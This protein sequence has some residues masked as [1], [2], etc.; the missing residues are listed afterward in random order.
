MGTTMSPGFDVRDFELGT[1]DRADCA[2]PTARTRLPGDPS[3]AALWR[4]ALRGP[5][6]D[7]VESNRYTSGIC[8]G[9]SAACLFPEVQ[10]CPPLVLFVRCPFPFIDCRL[11]RRQAHAQA[12][13]PCISPQKE[14]MK[15][16]AWMDGYGAAPHRTLSVG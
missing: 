3:L 13:D 4:A 16:L 10:S 2:Y 1:R 11:R 5:R 15:A 8:A 6:I 14:A 7:A 9:R 12:P